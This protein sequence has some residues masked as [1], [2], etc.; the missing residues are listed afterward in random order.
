MPW[1]K[2]WSS[3][4]AGSASAVRMR[5]SWLRAACTG[6]YGISKTQPSI[7]VCEQALLSSRNRFIIPAM[8][9]IINGPLGVGKTSISWA[10]LERF[11]RAVM[12]D[13]DYLGAVQPF[14]IY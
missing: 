9:V 1:T 4:A 5:I 6:G 7:D 3:T 14:E 13:G 8:I 10:L 12:L 11:E 2:F